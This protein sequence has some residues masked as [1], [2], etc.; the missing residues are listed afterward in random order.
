MHKEKE[1][2]R[3]VIG[4]V[5]VLSMVLAT[6]AFGADGVRIGSVDI[7]KVLLNSDAGKEAKE[8]LAGKGNRYEGEKNSREEELKQ[9]KGELEKQSVVLADDARKAKEQLFMQKR[10]EL[11][12]FLKD[13]QE[14]L[15]AKN[16]ELTSRL[17]E[18]IVKV[19][20]NYGKDKG[21]SYIFVK[22]DSMVFV[23]EKAD[24]TDE[25][26]KAF[27]GAKAK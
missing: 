20:Q 27:N 1:M 8:Q 12:R 17:V 3:I 6:A 11:D 18:Q 23:D 9:L 21:Y 16:D 4:F 19:I 22:N 24:L 2:K 15:Q 10:K 13:A 25:I 26:L 5:C 14:D 7:Q